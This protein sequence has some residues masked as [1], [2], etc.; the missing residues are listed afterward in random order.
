MMRFARAASIAS[1]LLLFLSAAIA[2]AQG[3][4]G[5]HIILEQPAPVLPLTVGVDDGQGRGFGFVTFSN[6]NGDGVIELPLLPADGGRM[7]LELRPSA[8]GTS[9]DVPHHYV[10]ISNSDGPSYA[11][12]P[13]LVNAQTGASVG[14]D[15]GELMVPP[16]TITPGQQFAATDGVLPQWPGIRLVDESS[17]PDLETFV[18]AYKTLPGFTGQVVVSDTTVQFTRVPEPTTWLFVVVCGM[19][20][21]LPTGR[22]GRSRR[23]G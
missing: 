16:S 2:S 21:L 8:A 18:Q 10:W 4:L 7:A 13:L 20:T 22:R 12:V 17:A 15:F 11:W 1:G 3:L 14:V 23:A 9:I 6:D 19:T 5:Y